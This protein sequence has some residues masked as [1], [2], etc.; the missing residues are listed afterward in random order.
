M[1]NFNRHIL[2]L[3]YG[4]KIEC[5]A[6]HCNKGFTLNFLDVYDLADKLKAKIEGEFN[7]TFEQ[8][9]NRDAKTMFRHIY[10]NQLFY[11]TYFKL[12][13]DDKHQVCIYD[14]EQAEADFGGK[15]IDYHIEFFRNGLNSI[16][17]M[18]L[19]GGCM[20]TPEQM[21]EILKSEYRGR[22]TR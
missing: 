15:Y 14:T 6:V 16:I 7:D 11:K 19:N 21:A 20:E 22:E 3:G 10:E 18:W 17:K 2:N 12:G 5:A 4:T 13:Y 1:K 9:T 8:V